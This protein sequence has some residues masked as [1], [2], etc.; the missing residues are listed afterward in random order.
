LH[1]KISF[2]N[3]FEN[4]GRNL[5]VGNFSKSSNLK[6]SMWFRRT[7]GSILKSMEGFRSSE[8]SSNQSSYGPFLDVFEFDSNSN[9]LK[10]EQKIDRPSLKKGRPTISRIQITK[11]SKISRENKPKNLNISFPITKEDESI[12]G[13]YDF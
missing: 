1:K 6:N 4:I 2:I 3:P 12:E 9:F 7:V 5:I 8:T 10:G 11:T 13:E